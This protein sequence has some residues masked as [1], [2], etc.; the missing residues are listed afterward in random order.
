MTLS[1]MENYMP[2]FLKTNRIDANLDQDGDTNE[3]QHE[4]IN[5]EKLRKQ[6]SSYEDNHPIVRAK[7]S[8]RND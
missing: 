2:M 5:K 4:S 6:S 1:S 8:S 7:S 3:S